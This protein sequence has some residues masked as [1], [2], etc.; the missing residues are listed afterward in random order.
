M[1]RITAQAVTGVTGKR[2]FY[3]FD[4]NNIQ[5]MIPGE[6]PIELWEREVCY[7]GETT[8]GEILDPNS[9]AQ[10]GKYGTLALNVYESIDDLN[11]KVEIYATGNI[12]EIRVPA[13]KTRIF[14]SYGDKYLGER[15]K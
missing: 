12:R 9:D 15:K 10:L 7:K 1:V 5:P 8:L 6:R 2:L 4:R 14:R 11:T 13:R 3:G